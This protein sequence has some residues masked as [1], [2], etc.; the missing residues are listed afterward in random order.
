M[1]LFKCRS[2][3]LILHFEITLCDRCGARLGYE[4]ETNGLL[5]L[6]ADGDAWTGVTDPA[7]DEARRVITGYEDGLVMIALIEADA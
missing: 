5:S 6:N 1:R 2:C 3:G 7:L 4:A